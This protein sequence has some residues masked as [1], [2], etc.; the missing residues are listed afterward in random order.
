MPHGHG[1]AVID[2]VYNHFGPDGNYLRQFSPDYFEAVTTRHGARRSTL[3]RAKR[4]GSATA[5]TSP[6]DEGFSHRRLPSMRP[7]HL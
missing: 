4:R 3:A 2:V 7:R 6:V 5:T 1:L